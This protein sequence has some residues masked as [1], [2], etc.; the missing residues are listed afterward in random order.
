MNFLCRCVFPLLE[1]SS[2]AP[3]TWV[4]PE[5]LRSIISSG[6]TV[7]PWKQSCSPSITSNSILNCS[8]KLFISKFVFLFSWNVRCS[9]SVARSC[10]ALCDPMDCGMPGLPVPNHL[11]G[12]SQVHAH[13]FSDTIQPSHPLMPSSPSALNLSKHQGLLQWV[14]CSH[15]MTKILEF[16]LQHQSFQWIFRVY[17]L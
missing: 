17:F 2:I 13:C 12:F 5:Q 6:S 9:C 15:Q 3:S 1:K 11:P 4:L 16:Q 7:W 8:F 10:S 14:S